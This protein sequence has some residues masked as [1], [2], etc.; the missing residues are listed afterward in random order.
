MDRQRE[1]L[2][3][4][5]AVS[6]GFERSVLLYRTRPDVRPTGGLWRLDAA[7]IASFMAFAQRNRRL[8]ARLSFEHSAASDPCQNRSRHTGRT[9]RPRSVPRD[10][11][12]EP[13]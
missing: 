12:Q 11:S 4:Q 9:N 8:K 6:V 5:D 10:A 1:G 13:G 2:S 7:A 3:R